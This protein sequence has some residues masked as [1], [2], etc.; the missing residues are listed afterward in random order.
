MKYVVETKIYNHGCIQLSAPI[1]VPDDANSY[2]EY[3]KYYDIYFD[4]FNSE[5]EALLYIAERKKRQNQ[6]PAGAYPAKK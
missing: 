6:S 2:E 3:R 5:Q 4:V 1:A